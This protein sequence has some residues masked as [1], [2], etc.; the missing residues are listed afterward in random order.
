LSD[1]KLYV[2]FCEKRINYGSAHGC[3]P[4]EEAHYVCENKEMIDRIHN[5]SFLKVINV[6]EINATLIP[7]SFKQEDA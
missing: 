1:S 6:Y 4:I 7:G 3:A 5:T 2:V